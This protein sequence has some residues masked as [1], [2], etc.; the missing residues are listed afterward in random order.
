MRLQKKISV[1]LATL[2]AVIALAYA[3]FWWTVAKQISAQIDTLWISMTAGGAQIE[4]AKPEPY[5]FPWPP[6]VTFSGTITEANG[7]V[8]DL[9]EL[10]LHGFPLPDSRVGLDAPKGLTLQGPLFPRPVQISLAR[11]LVFLP[12][13]LPRSMSIQDLSAWQQAKGE[14]P[15]EYLELRA[16]ELNISGGGALQLDTDLQIAG[17][18]AIRITGM[19]AMLQELAERGILKGQGAQAAQSFL[20]LLTQVDPVTQQKY[21]DSEIKIQRRGVYL[22]PL[23]LGS[24]PEIKWDAAQDTK[25]A[26]P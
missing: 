17:S 20:Q 19:E 23:R 13:N 14:I 12:A 5:G 11:L 24:L 16:G 1:T 7:T 15:I 18:I 8:W 21:F 26:Q 6:A 22:G 3:V 2:L 10:T 9:P 25:A 4:G